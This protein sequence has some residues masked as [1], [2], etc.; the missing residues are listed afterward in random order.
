MQAFLIGQTWVLK[1]PKHH[2]TYR[3]IQ[4]RE[5]HVCTHVLM[6]IW[7]NDEQQNLKL[8]RYHF[9]PPGGLG[10]DATELFK[11][12]MITHFQQS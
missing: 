2:K 9:Q 3:C 1:T 10:E 6:R 11:N 8:S 12:G 5:G 7:P 4:T